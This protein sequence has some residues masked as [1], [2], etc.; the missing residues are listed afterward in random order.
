MKTILSSI[1]AGSLLATLAVA[2]S[3]RSDV[4]ENI[5]RR[6]A[7]HHTSAK[8]D[9]SVYVITASSQFG[10][11]DLQTGEFVPIP[12]SPGLADLGIGN[13]LV[14]GRGRSTL[15]LA[16]S[17]DLYKIDPFTGEASRIGATGLA[18]C[19]AP[20]S[21]APNCANFIGELD[22]RLFATD[23]AQNLYSVN[24]RDGKARL[25]GPTG[26]PPLTFP[27]FREDPDLP[28]SLDVYAESLFSLHGKLYALFSTAAIN[29]QTGVN[30]PIFPAAI[31]QID[32]ETGQTTKLAP[33]NPAISQIVNVK[34]T[35]YSFDAFIGQVVT[36]DP[37]TWQTTPVSAVHGAACD[38]GPPSCVVA[39]ATA[40]HPV[41]DARD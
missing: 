24:P 30:T 3:S 26:V 41:R 15:S 31:Y 20:G 18:D 34:G 28:G 1:L 29:F 38:A 25:I 32:P 22:G 8:C 16:F 23:F 9:R 13:G 10:T 40:A 19:S 2:Q 27:P 5:A 14:Q 6:A 12:V 36:V 37:T 33:T 4:L 17:G 39:G 21:Y 35:L 11:V 7:G